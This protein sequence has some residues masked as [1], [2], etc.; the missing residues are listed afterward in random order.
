[1]VRGC[2]F[3]PGVLARWMVLAAST[4]TIAAASKGPLRRGQERQRA[5][6]EQQQVSSYNPQSI[7]PYPMTWASVIQCCGRKSALRSAAKTSNSNAHSATWLFRARVATCCEMCVTAACATPRNLSTVRQASSSGIVATVFCSMR[8]SYH[9]H[10]ARA[11]HSCCVA[12]TV[13]R[14]SVSCE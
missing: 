3:A 12:Y 1:M 7:A 4:A 11:A 2:R 5:T 8:V 9:R 13:S 14:T 6:R 10:C